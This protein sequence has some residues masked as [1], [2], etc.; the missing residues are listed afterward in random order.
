MLFES[1]KR[2]IVAQEPLSGTL[3]VRFQL[4]GYAAALFRYPVGFSTLQGKGMEIASGF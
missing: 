3:Q 2:M 4:H 1:P